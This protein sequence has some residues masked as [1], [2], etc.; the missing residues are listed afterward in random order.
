MLRDGGL[1]W[2]AAPPERWTK[3]EVLNAVIDQKE[4]TT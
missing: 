3:D 2:S 4:R 1:I